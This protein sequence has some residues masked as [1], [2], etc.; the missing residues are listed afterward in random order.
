MKKLLLIIIIFCSALHAQAPVATTDDIKNRDKFL[1]SV[2]APKTFEESIDIQIV[3]GEILVPVTIKGKTYQFLF[4]TGA[5]CALSPK[6]KEELHL[7]A[8]TS[9]HLTDSAGDQS[10]QYFYMIKSLSLGGIT[11]KQ[12]CAAS[13]DFKNLENMLCTSLDGVIGANLMRTCNWRID[14]EN[15]KIQFSTNKLIPKTDYTT[16]DFTENFS[17]SPLVTITTG[18]YYFETIADTGNNG[19]LDISEAMYFKSRMSE[20]GHFKKSIGKGFYSFMGNK[21]HIAYEG[22]Q[23][24]LYIG[25]TLVFKQ[26]VRVS[27]SPMFMLG[28]DFFSQFGEIAFNWENKQLYLPVNTKPGE[29]EVIFGFTPIITEGGIEVGVVYEDS[30]AQKMGFEVG[31]KILSINGEDL[32]NVS[33]LQWCKLREIFKKEKNIEVTILKPDGIKKTAQ[34]AKYNLL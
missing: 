19:N 25:T 14:Y 9:S 7:T 26:H 29:P 20:S 21:E 28:N 12:V 11:F 34:L 1:Y 5:T 6:L 8:L 30:E 22:I 10:F 24:S 13:I 31:D 32:T 33:K 16:T 3:N 15:K 2:K 27:P 17:G 18:G 4:D 23:D